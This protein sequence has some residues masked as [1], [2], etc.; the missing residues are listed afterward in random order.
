MSDPNRHLDEQDIEALLRRVGPRQ[1]PPSDMAETIR[2]NVRQAWQAEVHAR[3]RRR[4]AYFAAAASLIVAVA[5]VLMI[6]KPTPTPPV[7]AMVLVSS[8]GDTSIVGDDGT[9]TEA[10]DGT[11]FGAATVTTGQDDLLS[12]ELNRG[13]VVR[14]NADTSLHVD[15]AGVLRVN[16]GTIYVDTDASPNAALV[17]ETPF[18]TARDIGTRFEVK[19]DPDAWRVQV[20]DGHVQM[21][22]GDATHDAVAGTRV[23]ITANDLVTRSRVSADDESWRWAEAAAPGFSIEGAS[24]SDFLRWVSRETGEPVRFASPDTEKEVKRTILHGSIEGLTPRESL[25]AVLATTDFKLVDDE[26]GTIAIL[27]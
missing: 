5:V 23:E 19:V 13:A 15:A 24:L 26:P 14:M 12:I 1:A 16:R 18:G 9:S 20:R 8:H 25:R 11:G 10:I 22:D 6:D 2:A 7:V 4:L 17:V 27:K 21:Q 3:K